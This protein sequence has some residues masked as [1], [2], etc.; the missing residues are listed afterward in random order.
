MTISCSPTGFHLLRASSHS[1]CPIAIQPSDSSRAPEAQQRSWEDAYSTQA[2]HA[3]TAR[4][5]R[6]GLASRAASRA[7][8]RRLPSGPRGATRSAAS[9]GLRASTTAQPCDSE[10]DGPH[11][12]GCKGAALVGLAPRAGYHHSSGGCLL[13]R[14]M[15]AFCSRR[16]CLLFRSMHLATSPK[17]FAFANRTAIASGV[18][19]SRVTTLPRAAA[20]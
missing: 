13:F 2:A 6:G 14:S 10:S 15:A 16:G 20:A 1:T 11:C 7:A 18:L 9:H 3:S 17:Y 4:A 8:S 12:T 19:S 5:T